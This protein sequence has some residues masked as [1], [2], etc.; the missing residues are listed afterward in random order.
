MT[1]QPPQTRKFHCVGILWW[2]FILM[3]K[4][5]F[6]V[7]QF[8]CW[9]LSVRAYNITCFSFQEDCEREICFYFDAKDS[10][11][12]SYDAAHRVDGT[13][14]V[15][16]FQRPRVIK[17][18]GEPSCGAPASHTFSAYNFTLLFR[19]EFTSRGIGC[20]DVVARLNDTYCVTIGLRYVFNPHCL[21]HWIFNTVP[22]KQPL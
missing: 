21:L 4:F 13:M 14:C 11:V 19:I 3:A 9:R 20:Y 5:R 18:K 22:T 17:R 16:L 6:I 8:P 7:L 2:V 15:W 12:H 10:E 1:L